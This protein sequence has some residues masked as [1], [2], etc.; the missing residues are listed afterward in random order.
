MRKP[1]RAIW[2]LI[3]AIVPPL[4]VSATDL[5]QAAEASGSPSAAFTPLR[6]GL[7]EAADAD[8]D[9][10]TVTQGALDARFRPFQS[11]GSHFLT[12][13]HW[14]LIQAPP[15]GF[16]GAT[17]VLVARSGLDQPVRVWARQGGRGIPLTLTSS[18]PKFGG[19]EDKVFALPAGLDPG[20]PLYAQVTRAGRAVTDLHFSASTLSEVLEQAAEHA[21]IIAFTFGALMAM[22]I[23]ALLIRFVLPDE[24]YP[25]YGVL[26]LAAGDLSG[27]LLRT[28]FHLAAA[29]L[30]APVREFRLQRTGRGERGG[31]GAVRAQ[32]CQRAALLRRASTTPSVGLRSRSWGS[33]ARTCCACSAS[34]A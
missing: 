31:R 13:T 15:P 25:L 3:L 16:A 14:F 9:P 4:Y 23:S 29:R 24:I 33:R 18:I 20:Q 1:L 32:V 5:P 30:C 34:G 8:P 7:L 17:P 2:L 28:R 6:T 11:S 10:E 26:F 27:V 22:A 12:G 21:R 19:A